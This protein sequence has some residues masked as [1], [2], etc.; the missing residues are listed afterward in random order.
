MGGGGAAG[1][2]GEGA[3]EASASGS[4]GS[5][6]GEDDPPALSFEQQVA[7]AQG[8]AKSL[9]AREFVRA[10]NLQ[11]ASG[12]GLG[13]DPKV[14]SSCC[15]T[16]LHCTGPPHTMPGILP[17]PSTSRLSHPSTPPQPCTHLV[18]PPGAPCRW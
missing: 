18:P 10:Y 7:E 9:A 2:A 11:K 5:S 12:M 13:V 8:R 4:S 14:S 3:D 15:C 1:A 17:L 16:A 6:G